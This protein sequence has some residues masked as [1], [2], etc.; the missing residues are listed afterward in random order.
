MPDALAVERNEELVD[1][2]P[3]VDLAVV[4]YE[5]PRQIPSV[6]NKDLITKGLRP[7]IELSSQDYLHPVGNKDLI[8]K[9]LRHPQ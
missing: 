9:G 1:D 2:R 7:S 8:T 6:G 3:E 4:C 5:L